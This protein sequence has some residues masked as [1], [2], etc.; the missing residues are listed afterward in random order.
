MT[1]KKLKGNP[2][3]FSTWVIEHNGQFWAASQEWFWAPEISGAKVF[4][5]RKSAEKI[6]RELKTK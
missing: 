1:I 6:L 4:K 3:K 2:D 5:T